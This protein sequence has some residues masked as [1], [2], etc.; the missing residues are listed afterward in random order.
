M[1]I[2]N[3]ALINDI[4]GNKGSNHTVHFPEL[5]DYDCAIISSIF[6]STDLTDYIM[7]SAYCYTVRTVLRCVKKYYDHAFSRENL[8]AESIQIS[9]G[10][11]QIEM[12]VL[13]TFSFPNWNMSS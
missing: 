4:K 9:S 12:S 5:C 11:Y 2:I 7:N 8:H 6:L 10:M 3:S 1:R 13:L